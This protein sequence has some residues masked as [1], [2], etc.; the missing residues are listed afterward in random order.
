VKVN[1]FSQIS[2]VVSEQLI[3]ARLGYAKGKTQLARAQKDEIKSYIAQAMSLIDLQGVEARIG[4]KNIGS[5][6]IALDENIIL[7]SASLAKF[8]KGCSEVIFMAV[9][10]GKPIVRA[11]ENNSKGENVYAAV[12]FD[13][14][15]S[16]I[17]DAGLGWIMQYINRQLRRQNRCVTSARFSA[18]YGDFSLENQRIIWQVLRLKELGIDLTQSNML[19][20]EKSVT[21]VA[22]IKQILA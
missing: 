4:I 5:A 10:A 14:V 11:I 12:I 8:L 3:Y 16:E 20:P 17:T 15:A 18:G 19:V 1:F 2:V 7:K 22:G 13:A 9:T 21:A 6:D